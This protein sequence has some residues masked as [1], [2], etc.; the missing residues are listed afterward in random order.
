MI[1]KYAIKIGG[2]YVAKFKHLSM[3]LEY[4]KTLG[5]MSFIFEFR[6][7]EWIEAYRLYNGTITH[8]DGERVPK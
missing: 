8:A 6:N 7:Y 5:G 4:A 2:D 3:C 1:F